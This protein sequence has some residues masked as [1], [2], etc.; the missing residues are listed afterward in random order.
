MLVNYKDLHPDKK[1][2]NGNP[3]LAPVDGSSITQ[4]EI[5]FVQSIM[6]RGV[7][8]NDEQEKIVAKILKSGINLESPHGGS[9]ENR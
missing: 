5:E 9:V 6:G 8:L 2:P 4:T 1:L 7:T 3:T